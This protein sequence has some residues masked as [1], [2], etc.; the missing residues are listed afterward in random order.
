MKVLIISKTLT[1]HR[2]GGF[3]THVTE[4][5][6]RLAERGHEVD[7]VCRPL[8]SIV[9]TKFDIYGTKYVGI[10]IDAVD[11]ITSIPF[12]AHKIRT[13]PKDYDIVHGHG[14]SAASYLLSGRTTPFVYTLHGVGERNLAGYNKLLV[15]LL[16]IPFDVQK[17]C[18]IKADKVIC[19]S[20]SMMKEGPEYYKFNSNKCRMVPSALDTRKFRR[21]RNDGKHTV[22]FVGFLHE[23][24]G[25]HHLVEAMKQVINEVPDARLVVVGHGNVDKFKKLSG[26]LGIKKNVTFVEGAND[27][28]L[29]RLYNSFDVFCLPSQY[30]SFGLAAH[31]AVAAGTPVVL[32]K[33]ADFQQLAKGVGFALDAGDV[34][35]IAEKITLL[36]QDENLRKKYSKNCYRKIKPY[37]W[38]SVIKQI[39][40]LYKGLA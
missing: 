11:N 8:K 13:I 39:E 36:L 12:F 16:K 9:K 15:P 3:E 2:K 7:I 37:D 24:K 14:T 17:F 33:T 5:A 6:N 22:G 20:N 35:S 31:E 34:D 32:S 30:E 23:R 21:K 29:I 19:Q 28:E 27:E 25:I 26:N 1:F 4:L 40:T 18:L 10:D 38:S